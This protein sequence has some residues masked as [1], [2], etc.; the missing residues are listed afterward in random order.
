M[1]E[2]LGRGLESI[3][4]YKGA[5]RPESI[6]RPLRTLLSRAEPDLREARL[7]Q[8]IGFASGILVIRFLSPEKY[9][10]YTLAYT[11]LG[12]MSVL[13]DYSAIIWP[14]E[15]ARFQRST[16]GRFV[17]VGVQIQQDEELNI[18]VVTPLEGA[19]A[20]RA[21]I[22]TG[23]IIRAVNG[24]ST[25]GFTL[26]QAVDVITGPAGTEV[27]LT[28]ERPN[29]EDEDAEPETFTV[30]LT[31]AR[32]PLATVKGWERTGPGDDDWRWFIDP[33]SGIG[34]VRL[35]QFTQTTTRD[36]DKAIQ[37]MR[38]EGLNGLILDLRFNPGGILDQAVS[39]VSRFIPAGRPVVRTVDAEGR[40]R[41]TKVSKSI[42]SRKRLDDI[43]V[44][45]LVNNGSAS[46]S[47][48]VSGSLQAHAEAGSADVVVVGQ[49]TF[50]KGS[51]QS[52]FGLDNQ[53]PVGMKLTETHYIPFGGRDIHRDPGDQTWGVEPDVEVEMLLDR[54]SESL[55]IRRD[56]DV[57]P[58][59][60]KGEL[61]EAV[62]RPDPDT[63]IEDGIDLQLQAAL[64]A[65]QRAAAD[66]GPTRVSSIVP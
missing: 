60:E 3:R 49:R 30:T 52:V 65:V 5:R 41:E 38:D 48:I 4:F 61:I 12:A 32:I 11:F 33:D 57:W 19:P 6:I 14:D 13:D 29:L 21:G 31:R 16:Q 45:V 42:P 17:G 24:K 35:T 59:D 2:A 47:E 34:Y 28:I 44:A 50:G 22:R 56:A 58:T 40:V 66:A 23:D 54:V 8:A 9:T 27:S 36:F 18:K 15:L 25:V 37:A 63:L 39:I 62:E 26:D 53:G 51:V 10:L 43:P 20:Q 64:L 1:Y 55:K 7:V 46:A